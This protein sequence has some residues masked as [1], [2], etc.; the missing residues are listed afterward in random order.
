MLNVSLKKGD[1]QQQNVANN[2][3]VVMKQQPLLYEEVQLLAETIPVI[4]VESKEPVVLPEFSVV[5]KKSNSALGPSTDNIESLIHGNV[6]ISY[7]VLFFCF[8]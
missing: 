5:K 3:Q 7:S 2:Q 4:F 1:I 8:C 6:I